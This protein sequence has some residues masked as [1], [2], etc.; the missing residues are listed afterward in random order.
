MASWLHFIVLRQKVLK[1]RS[2]KEIGVN[3]ERKQESIGVGSNQQE[4]EA[5][6]PSIRTL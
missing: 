1:K 4:F 5:G 2:K 3:E 6:F